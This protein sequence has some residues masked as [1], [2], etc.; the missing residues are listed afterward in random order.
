MKALSFTTLDAARHHLEALD[1]SRGLVLFASAAVVR[2]LSQ[3]APPQAVL[4]STKGEYTPQ[5][6]RSG[7]VTGFEYESGRTRVVE[8]LHPPVLSGSELSAAYNKV[9]DNVN[10][11]MLL[12][13]DGQGAMEESILSSLFFIAPEFKII[14]GSAADDG[15]GETYIYIGSR[16]VR[17]LGI[18]FDMSA[19]TVLVKENIYVPTGK[20]MLVTEADLFGR[21]VYSFNGRPAAEEYARVIGVP[22]EELADHFLSSPLGKR[23]EDDLIIASPMVINA[24]GSVT[25][26]S[27]VMSSTYVEV[28]SSADPLA[29]LEE[30]L[31]S[32]PYKPSFVL[33]INCT[34]RDQL[35]KR[36][37]LWPAFDDQM[38]G[39]CSNITGFISFGEQ[40]YKKHANQT[41][42]LLLVE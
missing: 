1:S 17:N 35:F 25:F 4:C 10:A 36:D 5:G 37:N 33:N 42:I 31:G 14:G 23:Y 28:L 41:M 7:A 27:Q 11:F 16:R 38:L 26:Y 39:F 15:Q 21:R 6:Y 2:E 13:C 40:Y 22:V 34:L 20:T 29:V 9:K 24:D 32:S 8:I 18:F 3:Y 19:R 30:T 12:L